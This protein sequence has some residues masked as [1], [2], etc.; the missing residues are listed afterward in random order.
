MVKAGHRPPA[1]LGLDNGVVKGS[2]DTMHKEPLPG[3][4]ECSSSNVKTASSVFG[5]RR[6]KPGRSL[7]RRDATVCQ[8]SSS[9]PMCSAAF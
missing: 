5:G 3:A 2:T 4:P 1:G 8:E 6:P 9:V 7:L